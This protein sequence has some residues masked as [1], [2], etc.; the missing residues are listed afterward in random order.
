MGPSGTLGN[1]TAVAVAGGATYDLN[2]VTDTIASLAG[3][4]DVLLGGGSLIYGGNGSTLFNGTMDG[5]GTFTKNGTGTL[6][7]GSDLGFGGDLNLTAGTLQF[8]VTNAFAGT[9]TMSGGTLL[10]TGTTGLSIETLNISGGTLQF[11][12]S[13][14]LSVQ[15]LNITG[16]TTID[17]AGTANI[18]DVLNNLE[19]SGVGT[20][21]TIRNWEDAVDFFY[22][23]NWTGAIYDTTGVS[24]MNR[25]VF[26]ADGADPTTWT[27]ANTKWQGYDDQ[28]T[29]VPEPSTYGAMLLGAGLAFFGWRRWKQ[30]PRAAKA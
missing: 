24:P 13:S 25:I 1:S 15:N 16:S 3:S 7:I 20:Q 4:G 5:P 11:N 12:G 19:I 21:V 17:F 18:L 28:I 27:A 6:I 10:L 30:K 14:G 22:A 23:A 2:G 9:V 26:D 8:D 29:P